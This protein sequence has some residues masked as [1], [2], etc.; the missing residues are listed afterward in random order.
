MDSRQNT[1]EVV[2]KDS[3]VVSTTEAFKKLVENN[4]KKYDYS[5]F[6]DL[7]RIG[8]GASAI[9]FSASLGNEKYALKHVTDDEIRVATQESQFLLKELWSEFKDSTNRGNEFQQ[10]SKKITDSIEK[11]RKT[12]E[13]MFNELKGLPDD[14][15][16][17]CLF[18]F[19]YFIGIGTGTEK[20]L[21]KAF[22]IFQQ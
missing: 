18:G 6:K 13:E 2:R 20:Q 10:I 16:A 3:V 7:Q 21:N 4:V 17:Q 5:S 8:R 11:N 19:F 1:L 12:S 22:E 14:T 9:V 15:N